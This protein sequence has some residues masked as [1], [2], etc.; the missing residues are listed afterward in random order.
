MIRVKEEY[1][2]FI[3]SHSSTIISTIYFRTF[4][5]ENSFLAFYSNFKLPHVEISIAFLQKILLPPNCFHFVVAV[6]TGCFFLKKP[7]SM[8][9]WSERATSAV[10]YTFTVLIHS[11]YM[12][13]ISGKYYREEFLALA[14]TSSS[15]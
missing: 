7:I 6:E 9:S 3:T 15:L 10:K 13:F 1:S 4:T 14:G 2:S 5:Q 12:N 8:P 11:L